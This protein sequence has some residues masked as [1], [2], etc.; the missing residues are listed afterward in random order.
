MFL[1][2]FLATTI[3]MAPEKPCKQ[4]T[5]PAVIRIVKPM[6]REAN[7]ALTSES[8]W[9]SPSE[10]RFEK[11]WDALTSN[12]SAVGDESIAVLLHF[13]IG[14]H[15]SEE[16]FDE[17]VGRGRRML[18]YLRKYA[19]CKPTGVAEGLRAVDVA[20]PDLSQEVAQEIKKSK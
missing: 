17:A 6:L 13:Y 7:G 11:Y 8:F 2:L 3:Q 18:P 9:E 16:L 1:S 12:R 15:P 19:N 4:T 5:P 14:E 20:I 10:K